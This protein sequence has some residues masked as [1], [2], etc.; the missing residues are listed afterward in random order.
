MPIHN[1]HAQI[2]SAAPGSGAHW[3]AN[4]LLE[5]DVPVTFARAETHGPVW[6]S[7]PGGWTIHRPAFVQMRGVLP[8]LH[9]RASFAFPPE[10]PIVRVEHELAQATAGGQPTIVIVRDPRDS[11]RS[12]F[13]GEATPGTYAEFLSRPTGP[14][15][16]TP[17]D[18]WAVQTLLWSALAKTRP[19]LFA[20][21]EDMIDNAGRELA[22][23]L[24]FLGV[25]REASFVAQAAQLSS[26]AQS[27]S[28]LTEAARV[29]GATANY[30]REGKCGLGRAS[31]T[32]AE[33]AQ[34][35]GLTG[36]ALKQAGYPS[37]ET[38]MVGTGGFAALQAQ[39]SPDAQRVLERARADMDGANFD[40]ALRRLAEAVSTVPG[41]KPSDAPLLATLA[42]LRW[43]RAG[44]SEDAADSDAAVCFDLFCDIHLSLAS[45]PSVR[46]AQMR[47]LTSVLPA[48]AGAY[49]IWGKMLHTQGR[50]AEAAQVFTHACEAGGETA[51]MRSNLAVLAWQDGRRDD[52]L[53]QIARAA[54]L[55]PHEPGV[56]ANLV[57][58]QTALLAA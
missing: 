48:H 38:R 24:A 27:K 37:P 18:A 22:R 7:Q 14:L 42:A 47:E 3:L 17:P 25:E 10:T 29:A 44:L 45:T 36:V 53:A 46:M 34:F 41:S 16:L 11:L 56:Q 49:N 1:A 40:A 54:Q 58:M 6:N 8:A 23:V 52:A 19:V 51:Q 32:A 39:A 26:F 12:V 13:A 5:A 28:L 55:D 30:P 35:D 20:R 9:R 43:T 31:L 50:L 4:L 2:V 21:Y 15:G 57:A 33:N